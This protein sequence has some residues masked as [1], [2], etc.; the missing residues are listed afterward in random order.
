[1]GGMADVKTI[2]PSMHSR[3][4]VGN[5]IIASVAVF[6]PILAI[7]AVFDPT[8]RV[9]HLFEALLYAGV[10]FLCVRESKV[11]YALGV[12]SGAFWLLMAWGL[13]TFVKN[14]FQMV[15]LSIRTLQLRRPDLLIAVPAWASMMALVG[16]SIWGYSRL[17][18][19]S[20]RDVGVLVFAFVAVV[21][22]Y[23]AIFAAFTPRYLE[24]FRPVLRLL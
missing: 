9:L 7:A 18:R 3:R 4:M 6:I 23:L 13:T 14:G 15:V 5:G 8:I 11:G 20:M 2:P 22:F 16:L 24:M 1:M 17:T 19:K 21:A 12:A 10:A